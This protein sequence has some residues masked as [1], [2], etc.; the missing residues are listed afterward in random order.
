MM[1]LNRG[2]FDE[3]SISMITAATVGE[4]TSQAG[5]PPD[6]RRFRPNI[7][8]STVG[9]TPFQEDEWVGGTISFGDSSGVTLGV[10]NWDVRCSMVNIDPDTAERNAEVLKTV[11]RLRDKRAGVY[12]TVTRR[13][14]LTVGQAV[15][16]EKGD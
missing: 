14:R 16:I 1:H 12:C 7:L 2:I 9:A 11:V 3:A 6:V 5:Q 15:F 4:I 10:T 8:I 13:G